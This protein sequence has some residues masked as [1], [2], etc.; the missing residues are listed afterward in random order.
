MGE[1]NLTGWSFCRI[2]VLTV[3]NEQIAINKAYDVLTHPER[4]RYYD[5]YGREPDEVEGID[6]TGLKIS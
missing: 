1:Q 6:L 4:K 3:C 5:E 2:A